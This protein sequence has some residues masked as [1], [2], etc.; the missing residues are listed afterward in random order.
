MLVRARAYVHI[1]V[2][3]TDKRILI[4]CCCV[5]FILTNEQTNFGEK[6]HGGREGERVTKKVVEQEAANTVETLLQ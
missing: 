6:E 5:L 1:N 2:M 3:V 4:T